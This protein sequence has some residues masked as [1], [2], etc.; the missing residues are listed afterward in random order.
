MSSRVDL[1]ANQ[2]TLLQK[3]LDAKARGKIMDV[4]LG[5]PYDDHELE[6]IAR[7]GEEMTKEFT[8]PSHFKP[9]GWRV[10]FLLLDSEAS[11]AY[12]YWMTSFEAICLTTAMAREIDLLCDVVAKS[13]VRDSKKGGGFA[14]LHEIDIAPEEKWAML[15]GVLMQGAM[16]VFIGHE[17]GHLSAGHRPAITSSASATESEGTQAEDVL[18]YVDDV[19]TAPAADEGPPP[20][21]SLR[22]NAHEVDADVQG[23]GMTAR[24]WQKRC[25]D[26]RAAKEFPPQATILKAACARPERLLLIASTGAAIAI[27]L[28]GFKTFAADWNKQPTHPLTAVRCVVG[29]AALAKL[30]TGDEGAKSTL[31][32]RPEC[33]EA[34]SVVHARLGTILRAAAK[35]DGKHSD[36]TLKLAGALN[37]DQRLQLMFNATGVAQAM[38][39]SNDVVRYIAQLHA[40]FSACAPLRLHAIRALPN[41][42]VEWSAVAAGETETQISGAPNSAGGQC[43]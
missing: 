12:A 24:Y 43:A 1:S 14:F 19:I 9:G 38:T 39:R 40:E 35:H 8:G 32:L 18:L 10:R 15:K 17:A 13:I 28:M 41:R 23:F 34:L 3:S 42:L 5:T 30:L 36:L 26:I 4:P 2:I 29:L 6:T 33:M 25:D 11:N 21:L 22:L 16:A 27:S 7:I 20:P 37:N 31:L